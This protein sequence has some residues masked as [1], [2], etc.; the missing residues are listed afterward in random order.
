MHHIP[1]T[2]SG[3]GYFRQLANDPGWGGGGGGTLKAPRPP[4]IR[5][6]SR[7]LLYQSSQYHTSALYFI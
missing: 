3:P 5:S 6:R 7:K 1:L 2:L 4:P